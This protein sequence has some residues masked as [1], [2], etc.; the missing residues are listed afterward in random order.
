MHTETAGACI[1]DFGVIDSQLLEQIACFLSC[2]ISI[3]Q[4]DQEFQLFLLR[5]TKKEIEILKKIHKKM[6]T[7]DKIDTYDN[8][9]LNK[10][11]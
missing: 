4:L 5:D 8:H 11:L 3:A 6:G 1:F 9:S 2:E 7:E 10:L